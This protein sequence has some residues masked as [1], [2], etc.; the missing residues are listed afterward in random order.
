[1]KYRAF[2]P[3]GRELSLLVLGTDV[4]RY[5]ADEGRCFELLDSWVELGG[6]VID[7]GREYG[8][9][10]D[11]IG[12]WLAARGLREELT[13]ITKGAHPDEGG[14][15]RMTSEAITFDLRESLSAL[16]TDVIDL[17]LLHRDDPTA[18]V[19]PIVETL[20]EHRQEGRISSFGAS[21]WTVARIA[22]ADEYAS[23][24]GLEQFMCSSPGLSLAVPLEPAW[25][26]CVGAHDRS[27]RAWYERNQLPVFAWSAQAGGYFAE[28][29]NEHVM[30]VYASK[31]NAE[32]SRR[33]EE[34]AA[35][36]GSNANQIAVAWVLQQPFPVFAVIG[37]HSAQELR[38]SVGA[39]DI[40]LGL[41]EARWLNLE[42]AE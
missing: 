37:P 40:E 20:N 2:P 38:S 4:L 21:N 19:A 9:A 14:R 3:L 33:A 41:D 22:E 27:S 32:R 29:R 17:Y 10:E 8:H 31:E 18:P 13:L 11:M 5:W 28:V 42:D 26:G 7:T 6:N 39:L 24:N 16:G 25:P 12:R 23:A 1:M 15:S 30:R 35:E 34:L 36:R